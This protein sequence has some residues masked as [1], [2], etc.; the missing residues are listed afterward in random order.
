[1]YMYTHTHSNATHTY[2]ETHG[3]AHV[4]HAHAHTIHCTPALASMRY[5]GLSWVVLRQGARGASKAPGRGHLVPRGS[6][7]SCSSF[8]K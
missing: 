7:C 8:G 2:T 5:S 1:M 4:A 3:Q 6:P